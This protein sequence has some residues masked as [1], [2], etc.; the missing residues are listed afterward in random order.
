MI[1]GKVQINLNSNGY[2]LKQ[3]FALSDYNIIG[4]LGFFFTRLSTAW[5]TV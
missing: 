2:F 1:N 5:D 4:T 3:G